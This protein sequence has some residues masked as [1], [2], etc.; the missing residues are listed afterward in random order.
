MPSASRI[1]S[2]AAHKPLEL[3]DILKKWCAANGIEQ[4][5]IAGGIKRVRA[6][7]FTHAYIG[8]GY[9]ICRPQTGKRSIES[10]FNDDQTVVHEASHM[11]LMLKKNFFT[12]SHY[13][14]NK[15]MKQISLLPAGEKQA[16]V[17][18]LL[19]EKEYVANKWPKSTEKN[20]ELNALLSKISR[21][22]DMI[23]YADAGKGDLSFLQAGLSG[24]L[25]LALG[26][27]QA[28]PEKASNDVAVIPL[29]AVG[30][31]SWVGN[32]VDES[33]TLKIP[34]EGVGHPMS[35]FH[36]FFASLSTTLCFDGKKCFALLENFK[37]LSASEKA[38]APIFKDFC[39][40]LR[41]C[42]PLV[43][44]WRNELV[45]TPGALGNLRLMN[46][47]V[48]I[49]KLDNWLRQNGY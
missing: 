31:K 2:E 17:K 10:S 4:V 29:E 13:S 24:K 3:T 26:K 28:Y 45:V 38:V 41:E 35:N 27:P 23:S 7:L 42:I 6:G 33:S 40:L 11:F 32:I 43:K 21:A 44:E 49:V 9:A 22:E 20:L 5:R 39:K 37:K 30:G 47:G 1:A 18:E 19:A 16:A 14:S 34:L 48:N 25:M 46:F 36:E 12:C 8:S 15:L